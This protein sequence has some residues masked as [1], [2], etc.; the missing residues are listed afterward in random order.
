MP[1]QGTVS[2]PRTFCFVP[3][4]RFFMYGVMKDSTWAV[5]CGT[6]ATGKQADLIL[7]SNVIPC[8]LPM[9]VAVPCG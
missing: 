5:A 6:G 8:A 1:F 7:V 2:K 9:T 3:E 4:N